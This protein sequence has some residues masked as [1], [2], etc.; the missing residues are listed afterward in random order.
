MINTNFSNESG[1]SLAEVYMAMWQT[2]KNELD[3]SLAREAELRNELSKLE[4]E[5]VE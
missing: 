1:R 4:N 5:V 2:V 3:K